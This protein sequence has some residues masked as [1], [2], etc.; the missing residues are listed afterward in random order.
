MN[1]YIRLFL[2]TCFFPL[3][4]SFSEIDHEVG[5]KQE[6]MLFDLE[7]ISNIIQN[8]Y[9]PAQWKQE[10]FGW[11]LQA[12]LEEARNKILT[13]DCSIKQYQQTIKTFLKSARDYHV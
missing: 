2:V 9:A 7:F 4:S 12:E 10:Y 5:T 6:R 13:S 11:S 8:H 3:L 1:Y